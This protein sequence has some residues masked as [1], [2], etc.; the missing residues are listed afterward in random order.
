VFRAFGDG[1]IL[2]VDQIRTYAEASHADAAPH[3]RYHQLYK[4]ID[5]FTVG[6]TL[7]GLISGESLVLQL[8]GSLNQT[9]TTGGNSVFP[10]LADGTTYT[11]EMG[12]G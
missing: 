10:A 12:C 7:T 1:R 11:V 5:S 2:V 9:R 6:G 8:N 3:I 4:A